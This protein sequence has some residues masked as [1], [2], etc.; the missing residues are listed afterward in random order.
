MKVRISPGHINGRIIAP[1]SKSCCHRSLICSALSDGPCLIENI[2]MS[3][4]INATMDCLKALGADIIKSEDNS[5]KIIPLIKKD[6]APLFNCRESGST[7]RFMIP[8][9]LSQ[10]DDVIFTGSSRLIERGIDVYHEIFKK[11]NITYNQ[12][13]NII[14]ISGKLQP[15]KFE[16]PGNVSSQYVSGL[17]FSLP[18]LENDSTV[19]LISPVESRPYINITIDILKNFN[20]E[21]AEINENEFFIRG[22][23]KYKSTE[24]T[25]PGDW[26]N[27]AAL[28]CY[29]YFGS[30][31]QIENL[32]ES[33]L[34]GDKRCI[35]IF[36]SLNEGYFKTDISDCPDLAPVL[37][38]FASLK[39]GG[40]FTGT[41]RLK[42]K[43]CDRGECMKTSLEKF[44]LKAEIFDNFVKIYPGKPIPPNKPLDS[45]NDHRIV[46]ALTFLLS[47][48]GGYIENAEAV[49]KS[50]PSFFEILKKAGL[51]IEYEDK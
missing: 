5:F 39:H 51:D 45:F 17:L 22:N 44:G 21:I 35:E 10:Y 33:S 48:T 29:N 34:Q 32:D 4:D 28:L 42:I 36:N 31:A 50:F 3:D 8:V 46:M 2:E 43:E 20:I 23:Q 38:A 7:L 6:T 30:G 49:N 24:Y 47:F 19:K 37:F 12:N 15:G 16:L 41:K 9:A 18:L 27:G 25:V 14:H 26:S 1:P 11:C 13:N 40:L